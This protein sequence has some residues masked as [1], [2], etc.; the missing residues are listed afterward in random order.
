M[1]RDAA[2]LVI[3]GFGIWVDGE[4]KVGK[5]ESHLQPIAEAA[6]EVVYVCSGPAS[7]ETDGITY[8]PIN[9]S[10]WKLLT[11]LR[12]FLVCLWLARRR[13]FDVVVSFSLVPYGM[14]A[15]VVGALTRTPTHLGIIGS[16]LDVHANARYGPVVRWLFRRFDVVTV[17]GSD[18]RDR[19][20]AMGV[21]RERIFIVLHP[22]RSEYAAAS[23]RE[24]PD[25]DVL[26]LTR[27]SPEKDP[28][29][30][31]DALT[32]LRD[33]SVEFRAAIV[34]GGSMEEEVR[35]AVADRGLDDAV[36][37]PGWANSPVE[38]YRNA[39]VYVLT[40]EREMLPL[41]LVEAMLVGVPP[42]TPPLGA[43]PDIVDDGE[44]GLL[45][46]RDPV[47]YADAIERLLTDESFRAA[48]A[49]AAPEV[50]SQ[51]TYEAVGE[52]WTEIFDYVTATAGERAAAR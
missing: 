28:M 34:G 48:V 4:P 43:I 2:V 26:W 14:F 25:Y 18:F 29:L 8:H 5:I 24:S 39:R 41:S 1:D 31:V 6:D 44:N 17:S 37:V 9:R 46:D 33:R 36:D 20:V 21:R 50:E 38:Y 47:A 19:L 15:L 13:Q 49:A 3:A 52:A 51:L 30:F 42:V 22:V 23:V 32:E 45:V 12:Q 35:R 11:L 7:S 27:L 16:D 40:S 10:R